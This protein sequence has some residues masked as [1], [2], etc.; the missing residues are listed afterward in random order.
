MCEF[1]ETEN[2]SVSGRVPAASTNVVIACDVLVAASPD[3]LALYAKDRTTAIGNE[4]LQPTADFVT[5][6]D[7]RFDAAAMARRLTAACKR[8]EACPATSVAE[9]DLGDSVYAN[10]IMLGFTWQKGLVPVSARALYRAIHLNGVAAEEN[11]QAFEA[12]RVMAHDPSARQTRETHNPTPETLGLDDLVARRSAD[13]TAYQNAAYATRYRDRVAAVRA[14]EAGLGGEALTRAVAINLYKLM[15][16]KDEYEV[17]RLYANGHFARELGQTFTGGRLKVWLSPP[18]LAGKGRDGRPRKM[19]FGGWMLTSGFP[20]IARLKG[21][22]GSAWDPFGASV[23]RRMERAL[24][25][26]YEADLDRIVAALTA[27]RLP[28]AVKIAAIP[29]QIRGYGPVKEASVRQ[30]KAL[31]SQLWREWDSLT[32]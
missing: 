28:L 17:A 2:R 1:G 27:E 10:M 14:A 25:G 15:A 4:D 11:L 19:E 32:A 5:Q 16:Y 21:L 29:D 3:A 8:Y 24:I 13:L 22:R 26:Q 18:L 12:G 23:E 30:A 20:L 7:A 9:N 31:A 6:P